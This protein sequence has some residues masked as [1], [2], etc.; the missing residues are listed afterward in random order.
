MKHVFHKILST[1]MAVVVLFSTTSFTID[2][3]YCG[4]SLIDT[5]IFH[6]AK[7]CGME[8]QKAKP[9]SDCSITKKVCCKDVVTQHKGQDELTI[10]VDNL[11]LDQQIFLASFTYSYIN[12]FKGLDNNN[13]PFKHYTPPLV[14]KDIHVLDE[15]YLI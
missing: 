8:M 1:L 11:S 14:V 12:L 4:D 3:H 7:A 5:A 2:M 6:K 15:V 13:T 10:S 9:T